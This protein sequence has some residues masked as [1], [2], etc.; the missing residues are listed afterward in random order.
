[1]RKMPPRAAVGRVH[2]LTGI[3]KILNTATQIAEY[4]RISSRSII[5]LH[6]Q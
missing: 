4:V 1:M 6:A 2:L 5:E 3:R